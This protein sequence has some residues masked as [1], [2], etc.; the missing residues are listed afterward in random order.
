MNINYKYGINHNRPLN[1]YLQTCLKSLVNNIT[2]PFVKPISTDF[3]TCFIVGCGHSGTTLVMAKLG[4]HPSVFALPKETQNF[5]PIRGLSTSKAVA[6]EWLTFTQLLGKTVF[7]EKTPKHI[8]CI[9]RIKKILPNSKFII[10]LRNPLDNCAS[11]F[12]RFGDL[13]YAIER[14]VIDNTELLK[15]SSED[16]IIIINYETL[17]AKPICEF[18]NICLF[19]NIDWHE[20]I[21]AHQKTVFDKLNQTENMKL[22]QEQVKKKIQQNTGKWKEIFPMTSGYRVLEKTKNLAIKLGYTESFLE[23]L[24]K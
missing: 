4:N 10:M 2:S 1:S 8:H 12:N 3:T 11:L 6:R 13:N 9:K 23:G 20:S 5:Y 7:I 22:R 15:L 24:M 16:N 14:W 18:K 21:I 17:T 19:L